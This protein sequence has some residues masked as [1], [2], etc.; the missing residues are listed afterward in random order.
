[1]MKLSNKDINIYYN[2][3]HR[4]LKKYEHNEEKME[5]IKTDQIKLLDLEKTVSELKNSLEE[6]NTDQTLQ[7]R[8]PVNLKSEPAKLP[9]LKLKNISDQS[10]NNM[11]NISILA[12]RIPIDRGAWR[13]TVHG[14]AN[15]HD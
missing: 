5:T 4:F 10:L 12:W 6:L 13:A 11:W 9:K 1:M 7:D 15:R 2:Y 8:R 14:I 3:V